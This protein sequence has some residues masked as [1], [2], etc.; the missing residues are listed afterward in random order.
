[1]FLYVG[2]LMII[3]AL[4]SSHPIEVDVKTSA[5]ISEI[6]DAISYNKGKQ[7]R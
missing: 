5:Q 2:I 7:R 6:F 1:M 4:R 3:V